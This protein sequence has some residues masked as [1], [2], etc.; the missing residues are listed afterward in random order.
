MQPAYHRK[1]L[2]AFGTLMTSATVMMLINGRPLLR[3]INDWMLQQRS[4]T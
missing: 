2:A 4:C 1:G 3:A